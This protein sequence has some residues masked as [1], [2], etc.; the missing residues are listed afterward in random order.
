ML[1]FTWYP[2]YYLEIIL[3]GIEVCMQASRLGDL[4]VKNNLIT[5]E[6]LTKALEEQKESGRPAAAWYYSYQKWPHHRT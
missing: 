3:T 4:L 5:K 6:Q 2:K 1:D